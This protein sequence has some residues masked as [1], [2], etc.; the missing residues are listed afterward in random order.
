MIWRCLVSVGILMVLSS[1]YADAR[2]K[3]SNKERVALSSSRYLVKAVLA[4]LVDLESW[5]QKQ[6]GIGLKLNAIITEK[7]LK[8]EQV[9]HCVI[10]RRPSTVF[11]TAGAISKWHYSVKCGENCDEVKRRAETYAG[12][13]EWLATRCRSMVDA[14]LD[15]ATTKCDER[16]R[17]IV[18]AVSKLNFT[19]RSSAKGSLRFDFEYKN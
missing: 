12:D 15:R 10:D 3:L 13:A 1:G 19:V 2:I 14:G 9:L 11:F 18:E 16:G 17:Q 8:G 6:C 5:A 4:D 7:P